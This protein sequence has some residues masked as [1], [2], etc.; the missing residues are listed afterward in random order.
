[1]GPPHDD[2]LLRARHHAVED[3]GRDAH[4]SK[5]R[6]LILH[7]RNEGRDDDR[8]L[9][10][11]QCRQLITE[12]LTAAGR[13]HDANIVPSH[14][15]AHDPLLQGPKRTISP[16]TVQSLKQIARSGHLSS[17]ASEKSTGSV[18]GERARGSRRRSVEASLAPASPN[19]R[20]AAHPR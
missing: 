8:R 10:R 11:S 20:K 1:M 16:V 7:Q 3:G 6:R 13:H 4:L 12:R 17:I 19:T 2:T 18:T 15:A 9:A 14:D 5:L